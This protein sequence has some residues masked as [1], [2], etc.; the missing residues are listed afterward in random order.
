MPSIQDWAARAAQAI[1]AGE[2]RGMQQRVERIAALI[3]VHAEPLEQLLRESVRHHYHNEDDHWY[4]CGKC[5]HGCEHKGADDHEHY[6]DCFPETHRDRTS[7]VCDCGADV[8]NERVRAALDGDLDAKGA[9][10]G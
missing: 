8:W 4:C 5:T 2:G 3:A 6:A 9:Q 1:V 10:H 7:G